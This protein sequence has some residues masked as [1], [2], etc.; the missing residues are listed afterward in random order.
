MFEGSELENNIAFSSE[1]IKAF[2]LE[3]KLLTDFSGI[4]NVCF[5]AVSAFSSSNA[6]VHKESDEKSTEHN[7]LEYECSPKRLELPLIWMLKQFGCIV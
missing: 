2:L 1:E 4:E 7:S 6:V 3:K 5:F